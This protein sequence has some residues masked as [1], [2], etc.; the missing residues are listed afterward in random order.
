MVGKYEFSDYVI[1]G[2]DCTDIF[3]NKGKTY[4]ITWLD[5]GMKTCG[6][7]NADFARNH[8]D[9]ICERHKYKR[10]QKDS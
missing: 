8:A 5:N 4:W 10:E 1:G 3:G 9:Y 2:A 6:F 7:E